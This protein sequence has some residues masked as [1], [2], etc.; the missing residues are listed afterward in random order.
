MRK[1]TKK[2]HLILE[3]LYNRNSQPKTKLSKALGVTAKLPC[4]E[5]CHQWAVIGKNSSSNLNCWVAPCWAI[6][7]ADERG[8][9]DQ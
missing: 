3:I 6:A 1:H 9:G 4:A 7:E 8:R 5:H 2:H